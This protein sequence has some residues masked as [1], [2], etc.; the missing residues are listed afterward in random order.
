MSEE[1]KECPL[2]KGK[3]E[4]SNNS[5]R[6]SPICTKCGLSIRSSMYKDGLEEAITTWN[7]RPSPWITINSDK[8]LPKEKKEVLV[9][10]TF[11]TN[12]NS[13][14]GIAMLSDKMW[15]SDDGKLTFTMKEVT[16]WMPLPPLP[17]RK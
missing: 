13:Y 4:L 2:C 14:K 1:L 3:T 17:E 8:D 16:H 5:G 15:Y 12:Q 6:L 7:T 11:E 9:R 10:Y